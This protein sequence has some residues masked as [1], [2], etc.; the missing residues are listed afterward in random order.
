MNT[1]DVFVRST[2][3]CAVAAL[4]VFAA[5]P[6]HADPSEIGGS[7]RYEGEEFNFID[8]SY[9]EQPNEDS[10]EKQDRVLTFTSVALDKRAIVRAEDKSGA[11]MGQLEGEGKAAGRVRLFINE[12][13]EVWRIH[14]EA[15]DTNQSV[16]SPGIGVLTLKHESAD[17]LSGSFKL[18]GETYE[19][20]CELYFGL[21]PVEVAAVV[22][23]PPPPPSA[24]PSATPPP[25]A[26][27]LSTSPSPSKQ[28]PKVL[29]ADGGEIGRVY[30]SNFAAIAA[31]D[32]EGTVATLSKATGSVIEE[33]SKSMG[34]PGGVLAMLRGLLPKSVRI[35]GG[36][37]FGD[38]A[39]LTL[40]GIDASD[41]QVLGTA[42]MVKE[43][44]VWKVADPFV[45]RGG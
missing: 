37:D 36:Q 17:G 5:L 39:E 31:G 28:Q 43:E 16:S 20:A 26:P 1:R 27:L 15:G 11:I 45:K 40:E 44:G 14:L 4:M 23:A 34:S 2:R 8:G 25:S 24:P 7:C 41:V 12:Q 30:M 35:T 18:E 6:A 38:S 10:E 29:P 19:L 22:A 9:F 32:M 42:I 3:I 33:S 21:T 13:D